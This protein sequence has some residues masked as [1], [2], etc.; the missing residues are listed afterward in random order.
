MCATQLLPI[1]PIISPATPYIFTAFPFPPFPRL[2][3][4]YNTTHNTLSL[5]SP[6]SRSTP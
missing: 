2:K 4:T 3:K 5:H 6:P 1:E